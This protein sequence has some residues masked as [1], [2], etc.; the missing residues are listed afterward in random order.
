MN[1]RPRPRGRA[2]LALVLFA[3]C[4]SAS[5]GVRIDGNTQ[6]I[7]VYEGDRCLLNGGP[8]FV[9]LEVG[10]DH[11]LRLE[12][13]GYEPQELIITSHVSGLRVLETI[14]KSLLLPIIAVPFMWPAWIATGHWYVFEPET[15]KVQMKRRA[16]WSNTSSYTASPPRTSP[17]LPPRP[18][19]LPTPPA[20]STPAA[21]ARPVFCG[22][23]GAR[24]P[25]GARFCG[26][27][28]LP[29]PNR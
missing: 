18:T 24:L 9:T 10:R 4:A 29:S 7:R 20:P 5:R 14:G 21:A 17:P 1:G 8:T 28:G 12:A 13:D 26:G 19:T 2:L 16:G 3:S 23:C 25:S 22:Q 27:C 15:P 6:N 11:H